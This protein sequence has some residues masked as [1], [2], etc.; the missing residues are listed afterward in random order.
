MRQYI[1]ARYVPKFMGTYDPTQIYEALS[2]V[3]NGLGTSYISKVPTPAGTPLTDT[4]YWAIY[5]AT[6]GAIINLQNQIGDLSSL[7]TTDKDNLTD[8]INE[9]DADLQTLTNR[10]NS[11]FNKKCIFISDSYGTYNPSWQSKVKEY[12]NIPNDSYYESAVSGA[13][14]ATGTTFESQLTTLA[15]SMT[16]DVKNSITDIIV[17][18]GFNDAGV[19]PQSNVSLAIQSFVTYAKSTFPNAEVHVGFIGWS[20]NA[21]FV[22]ELV[23]KGGVNTYKQCR[24]F[25]ANYITNSELVMHD[26]RLFVEESQGDTPLYLGYAY[27]HP[28]SEGAAAIANCIANYL[29]GYG[30]SGVSWDVYNFEITPNLSTGITLYTGDIT[31]VMDKV[32]DVITVTKKSKG[33]TAVQIASPVDISSGAIIELGTL[34]AGLV[35]GVDTTRSADKIRSIINCV[36]TAYDTNLGNIEVS[37]DLFIANNK[38]YANLAN[39]S[40]TSV[41][42]IS[43]H[44]ASGT[45][46]ALVC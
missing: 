24:R 33:I 42:G 39:H 8:A 12:L 5:G 43:I 37:G 34:P 16:P 28:N 21:E 20:F 11:V 44:T 38:L 27:V 32:N 26:K 45:F 23:A 1:G 9:V 41:S 4:D 25:G 7:T 10:M 19:N 15:S 29:N 17:C 35:S 30:Y 46:P 13:G 14:F 31:F 40:A 36:M 3:D 2:V 18:G 6:S 22:S